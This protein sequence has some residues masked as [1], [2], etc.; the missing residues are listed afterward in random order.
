MTKTKDQ[1]HQNGWQRHSH[2]SSHTLLMRMVNGKTSQENHFSTP[3]KPTIHLLYDPAIPLLDIYPRET[4]T[5]V[6]K[7][8]HT[9]MFIA[10]LLV[11]IINWKQSKCP[12]TGDWINKLW[13]IHAL[14]KIVLSNK[15]NELLMHKT[16]LINNKNIILGQVLAICSAQAQSSLNR[17][18]LSTLNKALLDSGHTHSLPYFLCLPWCYSSW[19]QC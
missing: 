5:C 7:K 18:K 11:I 13:Y 16:T 17:P 19:P 3:L 12:S 4:K 9:G 15:E 6:L 14:T 10:V 8:P 2:G 1:P